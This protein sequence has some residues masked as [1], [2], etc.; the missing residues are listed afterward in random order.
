V[1][2]GVMTTSPAQRGYVGQIL[3]DDFELW[4]L[5][6]KLLPIALGALLI[7]QLFGLPGSGPLNSGQVG[8]GDC[9][10]GFG[11]GHKPT[12]DRQTSIG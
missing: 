10:F 4:F 5:P 9:A 3:Q 8:I 6:S 11:G 2:H 1:L 12:V 7:L